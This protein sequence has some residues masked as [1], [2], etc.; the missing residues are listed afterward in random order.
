MV[1]AK[2]DTHV[3]SSFQKKQRTTFSKSSIQKKRHNAM[4]ILQSK[5]KQNFT[6]K[7]MIVKVDNMLTL[8]ITKQSIIPFKKNLN[9]QKNALKHS[10]EKNKMVPSNNNGYVCCVNKRAVIHIFTPGTSTEC[11]Y[12]GN[13]SSSQTNKNKVLKNNPKIYKVCFKCSDDELNYFCNLKN[14]PQIRCVMMGCYVGRKKQQTDVSN[15]NYLDNYKF[16]WNY[17][18]NYKI[19]ISNIRLD[20]NNKSLSFEFAIVNMDRTLN[21]RKFN[22]TTKTYRIVGTVKNSVLYLLDF[23][24][25]VQSKL[26]RDK[27]FVEMPIVFKKGSPRKSPNKSNKYETCTKFEVIQYRPKI[28]SE[29]K[30]EQRLMN[31]PNIGNKNT[32]VQKLMNVSNIINNTAQV[33]IFGN[34]NYSRQVVIP[35]MNTNY[36]RQVVIPPINTNYSRQVIIPPIPSMTTNNRVKLPSI[37][38]IIND[39]RYKKQYNFSNGPQYNFN[40]GPQYNFNNGPQYNFN[41][42]NLYQ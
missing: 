27:Y 14:T 13:R 25:E 20:M 16:N 3:K 26:R 23:F 35:P 33:Q 5:K 18:D 30:Q 19:D 9:F 17:L 36:S 42:N 12:M 8:N 10:F 34:T 40:N 39:P 29:K 38:E 24:V 21:I 7:I 31:R 15:W 6:K 22:N 4:A 28:G 41:N 37:H 32:Q 2:K 11:V 1:I